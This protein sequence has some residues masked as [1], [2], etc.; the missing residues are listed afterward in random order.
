MW[1]SKIELKDQEKTLLEFKLGWNGILIKTFFNDLEK[2]YLLRIKGLSS[3]KF[4]L[5]DAEKNEILVAEMDT[6]WDNLNYKY[7]INTTDEFENF[8]HKNIMVLAL[9]H[10]I[11]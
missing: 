5:T 7:T 8:P 11:N 9:L 3:N 4:I 10:C 2:K 1:N 6:K